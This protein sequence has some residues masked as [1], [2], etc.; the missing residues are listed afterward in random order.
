MYMNAQILYMTY[1]N[2]KLAG[3]T[4]LLSHISSFRN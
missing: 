2:K 1:V 3:K 4:H